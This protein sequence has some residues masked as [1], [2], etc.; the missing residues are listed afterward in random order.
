VLADSAEY[1]VSD[2]VASD[3]MKGASTVLEEAGKHVLLF[4]GNAP[5]LLD[6]ADF[7]DG[8]ICYGF[9]R[10][11]N[12]IE[13]LRTV[14]KPVVTADFMMEGRPSVFVDNEAAAY[15]LA[16]AVLKPQDKVGIIGL[17]LMDSPVTCRIYDSELFDSASNILI[18]RLNGY[19][20]AMNEL[21]IEVNNDYIWHIPL[22]SERF[23]QQAAR[24][25]LQDQHLPNVVFCLSD[26]IALELL[27]MATKAD[28]EIPEQF[29]I[30]GFDGIEEGQR[31]I[32]NLTTISQF[33]VEKGALASKAILENL[34]GKLTVEYKLIIG[35]TT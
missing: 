15:E 29:K 17:R 19:I 14:S 7:V 3:F 4:A 22:N 32:K 35:K 33:S 20:R 34:N 10:N 24:E 11:P 18:Q 21:G 12:I 28:L 16:K 5:S 31:R 8:F 9:P 25:L 13:E 2:P 26:A 30:A 27:R 6:I 23:A 1:T